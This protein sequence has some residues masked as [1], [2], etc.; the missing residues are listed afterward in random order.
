V[1][2]KV[3]NEIKII[4]K[5]DYITWEEITDLLHLAFAEKKEKGMN[6]LATYQD[7]ETTKR[8]VGNG[9][10]W[11]A[12]LNEKVIGTE[13]I[14]IFYPDR[15]NRRWHNEGTY[16]YCSQ[17]AVHP[18]FKRI[19]LGSRIQKEIIFYCFKNN[20][21]E[22]LGHTS[23]RARD[24]QKWWK[25]FGAQKVELISSA[26]TNY[27]AVRM[28]IPIKGKKY[29]NYYV[30]IR[31]YISVIKCVLQKNRNGKHRQ[32]WRLISDIKK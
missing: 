16:A 3:I 6:Y 10:C 21:D 23:I 1:N 24:I 15:K 27:Y 26:A 2:K 9:V 19:G 20:I 5:P 4:P 14:E 11:V 17:A 18:Y 13:T 8:R 22:I 32:V 30:A 28:R 12:L 31:Y 25:K 7:A 29:N